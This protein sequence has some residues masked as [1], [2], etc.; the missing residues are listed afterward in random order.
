MVSNRKWAKSF[1]KINC[2]SIPE[3][4]LESELF[5]HEAGAFTGAQKRKPGRF[6]LAS[7]GTVFLDEVG[8]IPT[9]VQAKLLQFIESKKFNRVGGVE[10]ITINTRIISATN[11]P[12]ERMIYEKEFREDLYYRLNEYD[13]HV[14]PLR[15]RTED[16]PELVNYFIRTFG[17]EFDKEPAVLSSAVLSTLMNYSWPGNVRELQSIIKRFVFTGDEEMMLASLKMSSP[18]SEPA[19]TIAEELEETEKKAIITAL[20]EHHWNRRNAAKKL[21]MS[22]SSLRR[23]ISKYSLHKPNEFMKHPCIEN[24]HALLPFILICVILILKFTRG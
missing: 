18:Q 4:L 23:R 19:D 20:I 10:T 14:P 13:I 7:D 12:L 8:D 16:I 5:G 21:G 3:T 2:P 15:E 17:T 11:A 9:T 6:E 24:Q 1:V 22:Y